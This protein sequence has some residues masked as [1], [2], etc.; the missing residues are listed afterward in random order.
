LLSHP[1]G[2]IRL[3]LALA[4]LCVPYDMFYLS[5]V[6]YIYRGGGWYSTSSYGGNWRK[7]RSRELP[8]ELRRYRIEKIHAFRDREYRGYARDRDNYRGKYFNPAKERNNEH[9]DMREQHLMNTGI[10]VSNAQ[11]MSVAANRESRDINDRGL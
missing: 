9:R 6:Y 3:S 4:W 11:I 10:C 7:M 8:L 1:Q 2:Y 5:G